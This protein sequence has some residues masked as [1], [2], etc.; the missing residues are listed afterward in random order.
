MQ[1]SNAQLLDR[2]GDSKEHLSST[3]AIYDERIAALSALHSQL[4]MVCKEIE[5]LKEEKGTL[6][7]E[8]DELGVELNA[9]E[10][11]LANCAE[12]LEESYST[13]HRELTASVEQSRSNLIALKEEYARRSSNQNRD[14]IGRRSNG[15]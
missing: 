5:Q 7:A 10:K 6:E 9:E 8:R 1:Q 15:Q 2:I 3:Q 11:G 14:V 4:E 13:R 12:N